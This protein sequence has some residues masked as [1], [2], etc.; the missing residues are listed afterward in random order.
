M[1]YVKSSRLKLNLKSH[2]LPSFGQANLLWG[3]VRW[4]MGIMQEMNLN[5][6]YQNIIS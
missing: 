5:T 3:L 4:P 2:F 6:V 1:S